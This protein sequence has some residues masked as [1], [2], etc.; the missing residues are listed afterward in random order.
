MKTI[1]N[2][3]LKGGGAKGIAYL[4]AF[5]ELEKAGIYQQIEKVAGTSAGSITAMLASLKYTPEEIL[6]IQQ[7]TNFGSFEDHKNPVRIFTKYGLYEGEALFE[8]I[9][10]T[11]A[12]S[13][14][15]FTKEAT[16]ADFNKAGCL[17]L[18]V[19]ASDTYTQEIAEFS[20]EKTPNV[21]VAEAVRA[22]ASIPIFF[23][24][25]KFSN[26]VPNDHIY[27]DGGMMDNFPIETFDGNIPNSETLGLFLDNVSGEKQVNAYGFDHIIKYVKYNF[28]TILNA[29]SERFKRTKSDLDRTII[30]DDLGI[31]S[32]DFDLTKEQ[33]DALVA[34]GQ[35]AAK[36]YLEEHKIADATPA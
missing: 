30:I 21:A 22:S 27:V 32:T 29:Q 25:W 23:D 14:H 36:A 3:V 13:P 19:F 35:K 16:F 15:A 33:Q 17:D 20:F 34:S 18:H 4:G 1:K 7:K 10:N 31:S 12:E 8:W 5:M 24:A 26:N 2:L 6:K 9:Q 28:E 11:V